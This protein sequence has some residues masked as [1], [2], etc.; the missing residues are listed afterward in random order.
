LGKQFFKTFSAEDSHF[1]Q[2]VGA[3][4]FSRTEFSAEK[5]VR[6][7]GPMFNPK[8]QAISGRGSSAFSA[9]SSR[10]LGS[11]ES[12]LPAEARR[13]DHPGLAEP[14]PGTHSMKLLFGRKAFGKFSNLVKP[15]KFY[16][17][18]TDKIFFYNNGHPSRLL[19]LYVKA[20]K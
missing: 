12:G 17:K 7:I 4:K 11:T 9:R 19:W 20:T 13:R 14:L 15:L 6:K 2:H 8:T 18:M 10:L 1:Y 16:P 3:K 5:N